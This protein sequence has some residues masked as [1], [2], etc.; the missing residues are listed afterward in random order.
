MSDGVEQ[1]KNIVLLKIWNWYDQVRSFH[2]QS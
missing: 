2:V 1:A